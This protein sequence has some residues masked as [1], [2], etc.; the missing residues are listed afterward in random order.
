MS[1]VASRIKLDSNAFDVFLS[2]LMEIESLEYMKEVLEQEVANLQRD[3]QST[4]NIYFR[5]IPRMSRAIHNNYYLTLICLKK[6]SSLL[7]LRGTQT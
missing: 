4:L 6:L 7:L 3:G 1:A 2:L 5:M